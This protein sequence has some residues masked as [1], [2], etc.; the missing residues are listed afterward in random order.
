MKRI[1]Y[2]VVVV[3]MIGGICFAIWLSPFVDT[4]TYIKRA[5][6][7][8][9]AECISHERVVN[10]I[11]AEIEIKMVLKGEREPGRSKIF[12]LYPMEKNNRYF[13]KQC[14]D[15]KGRYAHGKM[16]SIYLCGRW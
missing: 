9:I 12:S 15:Q 7:I 4:D 16:G 11:L 1:L 5:K 6:D 14:L 8:V 3:L 13:G 2:T 10:G